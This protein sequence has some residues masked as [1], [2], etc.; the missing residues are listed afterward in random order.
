MLFINM[1]T[2]LLALPGSAVLSVIW[3]LEWRASHVEVSLERS[4]FGTD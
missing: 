4:S 2:R 3:D 1:K